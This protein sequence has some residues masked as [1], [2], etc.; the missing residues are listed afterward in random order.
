MQKEG[1]PE[2]WGRLIGA[3]VTSGILSAIAGVVWGLAVGFNIVTGAMW[4]GII[5]GGV[6]FILSLG[7]PSRRAIAGMGMMFITSWGI[8]VAIGLVVWLIRTLIG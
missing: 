3:T 7:G 5:G 8:V 6:A 2:Y 1:W 4:G